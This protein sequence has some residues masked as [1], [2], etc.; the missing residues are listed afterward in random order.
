MQEYYPRVI[1]TP[2]ELD[3]LLKKEKVSV[4][5]KKSL[6]KLFAVFLI[7]ATISGPAYLISAYEAHVVNI[8][9]RICNWSEI[10]S[11]GYWKNH[12]SVYKPHLPQTLGGYPTDE[13]VNTV[14]KA[15]NILTAAC[16]NCGCGC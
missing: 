15:N 10:R 5:I 13:V 2:M 8:T 4:S 9:A 6:K 14:T 7:I 16:G 11:C 12:S 1:K 3:K